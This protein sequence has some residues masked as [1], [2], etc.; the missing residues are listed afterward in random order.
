MIKWKTL[1]TQPLS[2]IIKE[3]IIKR[4]C[5]NI[6]NWGVTVLGILVFMVLVVGIPDFRVLVCG[7]GFWV[8]GFWDPGFWV[9]GLRSQVF[10]CI[11]LRR[12]AEYKEANKHLYQFWCNFKITVKWLCFSSLCIIDFCT[13]TDAG[14]KIKYYRLRIQGESR[15]AG[16]LCT[17]Y[18]EY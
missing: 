1:F 2:Y 17:S 12:C 10:L 8:P 14:D 13:K 7:P 11:R 18:R 4:S 9:P 16:L 3:F 6:W 5:S 15:K